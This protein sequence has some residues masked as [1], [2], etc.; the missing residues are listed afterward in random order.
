M[1]SLYMAAQH[2]QQQQ[3]WMMYGQ[4]VH[5]S[6]EPAAAVHEYGDYDDEYSESDTYS[7]SPSEDLS[8][9]SF[10]YDLV[11]YHNGNPNLDDNEHRYHYDGG[12]DVSY[13][14]PPAR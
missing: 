12:S 7:E 3:Q 14:D 11:Y 4:T 6:T 1:G 10:Q 2:Q 5:G 8:Q 13:E 9:A